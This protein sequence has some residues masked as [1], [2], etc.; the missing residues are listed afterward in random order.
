[1]LAPMKR[2]Y[3]IWMWPIWFLALFTQANSFKANPIIG[4]HTLNR[5]GL[6]VVRL[7][8][9]HTVMKLRWFLLMGLMGRA[10]RKSFHRDG[11]LK[12]EK[13]LSDA[14][15]EAL[16]DEVNGAD[17]PA[18]ECIQGDTLTHRI[19]LDNRTL[20]KMP[21]TRRFLSDPEV[22]DR[23]MYAAGKN[24]RPL[25]YIQ[26][27]KNGFGKKGKD[28]QKNLHADT[29]HPSMKAWFFLED[30]PTSKGPF[31]FVPGSTRLTW[32]RIKWEYAR[33]KQ[34]ATMQDGYSEKG[35]FRFN[36]DD[37]EALGLPAPEA[38][39]VPANTL[40]IGNTYGVHCRGQAE[41]GAKRIEIWAYSRF[42]P[43]NPWPGLG[44][45]FYSRIEYSLAKAWWRFQDR[46]ATK[47][48]GYS[49]WHVIDSAS[50][51]SDHPEAD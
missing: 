51:H 42:N 34:A 16:K 21:V 47:R 45:P 40:V 1:M 36:S 46:Q 12:V 23:L 27:I 15:L 48:G 17:S 33:S 26:A 18:R 32:K 20:K 25:F 5:M 10:E 29:F 7:V 11:Y 50:F 4:N 22:I 30:V 37:L 31:N 24:C 19:F 6:H 2:I 35:S 39:T 8:L 14:E 41:A 49:S 44:L 3:K 9:A 38:F 43:F 28:P 13:L